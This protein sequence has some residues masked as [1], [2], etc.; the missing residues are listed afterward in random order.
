VGGEGWWSLT[1]IVWVCLLQ[2]LFPIF[3]QLNMLL[4]LSLLVLTEQHFSIGSYAKLVTLCFSSSFPSKIY[5]HL[6]KIPSFDLTFL[7]SHVN[8]FWLVWALHSFIAAHPHFF[9]R[10]KVIRDVFM[11]EFSK[12]VLVTCFCDTIS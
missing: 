9:N 2:A 4:N 10:K 11:E 8:H 7:C 1:W 12:K 6:N 5:Q 3:A